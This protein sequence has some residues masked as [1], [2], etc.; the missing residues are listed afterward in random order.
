MISLVNDKID[1]HIFPSSIHTIYLFTFG[2][3]TNNIKSL[4]D[5]SKNKI[6][7]YLYSYD[8]ICESFN[9]FVE[10]NKKSIVIL[11]GGC[12]NKEID[13]NKASNIIYLT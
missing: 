5:N 10:N 7:K 8:I 4:L 6:N 12:F 3:K 11:N 9:D 13:L 1:I 2:L